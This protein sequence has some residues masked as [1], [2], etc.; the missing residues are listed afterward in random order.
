MRWLATALLM[1]IAVGLGGGEARAHALQPGYLELQLLGADSWRAFWRKP[2]VGGAPMP[3][4][5]SLPASCDQRTAPPPRFDGAAYVAQWL[6]SC[7][8]GIAGGEIAI[9]GLEAT[10][11]DVLVRFELEPGRGEAR[12]LTPDAPVFIVP[13]APDRLDVAR[14]YFGLGVDHILQGADHLL[15]VF[16]L[17]LLIRDPWRLV[18]AV[19]ALTVA[20]SLTLAAASLGW[21]VIPGAPVEAIVALSIMFL[22]SELLL[23]R[24][25][26]QRLTERYP[27]VVAFAFGLLHGLGFARALKEIGLPEGD[28]PLALLTFNLGVEAG[29]LLFI[30]VV[31]IASWLLRRLD[32]QLIDGLR[33]PRSVGL[34]S[35]AYLIGGVSAYW[36]VARVAAF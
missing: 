17:L 29:Q 9:P 32:P 30:S 34:V 16:A 12:R 7:P 24:E 20:H 8:G 21:L 33:R 26:E 31:L 27:W 13:T 35:M 2:A 25:G 1:V 3:I 11:T 22:A 23:E 10:R 36:F 18:A 14:R 5:V 28:V 4:E 19:S 15:F 6:A